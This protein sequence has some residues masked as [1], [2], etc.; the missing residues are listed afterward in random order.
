[1]TGFLKFL[2]AGIGLIVA[3]IELNHHLTGTGPS[4]VGTVSTAVV[5]APE[6]IWPDQGGVDEIPTDIDDFN[7]QWDSIL[8]EEFPET[9]RTPLTPPDWWT[10][11]TWPER[12]SG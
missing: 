2:T 3:V 12:P 5:E 10:N 6:I 9:E 4:V 8:E 11:D 7:Q 1:M